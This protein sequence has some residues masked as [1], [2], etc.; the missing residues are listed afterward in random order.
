MVN[1]LKLAILGGSPV[2]AKPFPAWPVFGAEEEERLLGVLRSGNWWRPGGTEVD[3]FEQAFASYCGCRHAIAVT[4]GT[5]ALRIA[6]WASGI[7]A[8]DEVIIPP[9]TFLATAT[10]VLECNATP[11]FVD[12]QPHTLNMNPE[13]LE[14]AI[15]DR[16]KAIVPVHLGGCA[17]DMDA[18]R[19]I[20][21]RHN[22]I[23]MEDAA[24]AHG[25]QYK[26]KRLGS[27]G[28]L[29][30]FSLQASKNLNCGEGGVIVTSDDALAEECR[31]IH[32]CGR[33]SSG[34]WFD[35]NLLSG[36]YRMTEFQGAI[37]NAQ[38]TR[39]DEQIERRERNAD[40]LTKR[41]DGLP[42]I[43]PQ[44][45]T[46]D[47]TRKAYHL[48]SFLYDDAVYGVP[49]SVYIQALRA[50]GI[51]ASE[52][53]TVPLYR[54]PLFTQRGFGPYTAA[55]SYDYSSVNCPVCDDVCASHG[56]WL[57]HYLL[58]GDDGDSDDIASAFEKLYE[59]RNALREIPCT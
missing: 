39:L 11:V 16:T 34:N 45:R 54:Q 41:L 4:S 20:A 52:G 40:R 30:C 32:N 19:N 28:H 1:L 37:L 24:H 51:P 43:V 3:A 55:S 38:M 25:G 27:I 14:A 50:E 58:L 18:I 23:V 36:N 2:R 29:G 35:R 49:R 31:A 17:A 42:G 6:L 22:L 12:I 8:G 57:L 47:E 26:R 48:Y 56:A 53:Y 46:S 21:E 44:N 59:N 5:V 10:S 7:R 13:L 33:T 9:Y 15:T